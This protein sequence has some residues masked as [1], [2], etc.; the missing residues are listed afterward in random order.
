MRPSGIVLA[1]LALGLISC[2]MH[3][4]EPAAPVAPDAQKGAREP[5]PPTSKASLVDGFDPRG[6]Q[7]SLETPESP[8][9]AASF[10]AATRGRQQAAWRSY[11]D[12]RVW[13]FRHRVELYNWQLLSSQVIFVA[14]LFL[15]IVGI[16]FSW[17]QFRLSLRPRPTVATAAVHAV[18]GSGAKPP[19]AAPV[20]A[21]M[22]VTKI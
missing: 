17:L 11:Y 3:A 10:D 6:Q 14:V 21:T 13:G 15:V 8:A 22:A 4:G 20:E 12:Y 7:T 1:A 18:A 19:E 2:A 5:G 9:E 16:Y